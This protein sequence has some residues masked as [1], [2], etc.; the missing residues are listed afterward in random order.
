[1][2]EKKIQGSIT[3]VTV[4]DG[5]PG[6]NGAPGTSTYTYVRYA[7]DDNGTNISEI[8]TETTKYIGIIT[9]TSPT[10]P[11]TGYTWSKYVGENG[12]DGKDGVDGKAGADGVNGKSA[13]QLWLDAGN[14][15][16][17]EDY[18]NSLKGQDG[19]DGK[20]GTDGVGITRIEVKYSVSLSST[21][22]PVDWKDSIEQVE[23]Q[24]GM[25]FWTRIETFYSDGSSTIAHSIA[26]QGEK[27]E[28]GIAESYIIQTNVEEINKFFGDDTTNLFFSPETISFKVLKENEVI[29]PK[30][31]YLCEIALLYDE[32]I[33]SLDLADLITFFEGI[34]NDEN[35]YGAYVYSND[36]KVSIK[37][38]EKVLFITETQEVKLDLRTLINCELHEESSY[39]AKFNLLKQ[40]IK[41]ET[42]VFN[43]KIYQNDESKKLITYKTINCEFGLPEEMAKFRL[44]ATQI[45]AAVDNANLIFSAEGLEIINGGFKI[46]KVNEENE[47]QELLYFSNGDLYVDGHG[48]FSGTVIAEKGS[49]SGEIK[50]G[51]GNIGGFIIEDGALY[52]PDKEYREESI[53]VFDE[54]LTYYEK[55]DEEYILTTDQYLF[56][57]K[58]Y[59]TLTGGNYSLV[60][61][62]QFLSGRIYFELDENSNYTKVPDG[63][64]ANLNK[65][66]YYIGSS[67]A[68]LGGQN[69]IIANDIELGTGAKILKHIELGEGEAYIYNP[70]E[71]NGL[72]L[73]TGGEKI[74]LNAKE[75]TLTLG[76]ITLNGKASSISGDG[77]DIRPGFS[78]FDNVRVSG[79][80]TTSIFTKGSTQAVGG[81]MLFKTAYKIE[82]QELSQISPQEEVEEQTQDITFTLKADILSIFASD[83]DVRYI[84]LVAK[85]GSL[86]EYFEV[87]RNF[88]SGNEGD[89]TVTITLAADAKKVYNTLIVLGK[90]EDIIIGVNSENNRSALLEPRGLTISQLNI[91]DTGL[92]TDL[93]AFLGDLTSL[94]LNGYGLYSNNVYLT[95]SLTTES[96]DGKYA[97][98]NTLNSITATKFGTGE[99]D[100][101]S[102]IVFW[103]GAGDN[104]NEAIQNAS[105]QVTEGGSIYA[106]Q[107]FFEDSVIAR[108]KITGADIYAARLHGVKLNDDGAPTEDVGALTVYD[109]SAG[110]I[111]KSV[112]SEGAETETF[113]IG[114]D[115]LKVSDQYFITINDNKAIFT[116]IGFFDEINPKIINFKNNNNNENKNIAQLY[117]E[118]DSFFIEHTDSNSSIKIKNEISFRFGDTESKFVFSNSHFNAN[119]ATANFS[120][121]IRLGNEESN[122]EYRK[123]DNGKGYDLYVF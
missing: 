73:S 113:S 10:A 13:Y 89:E 31:D 39:L 114:A 53:F 12:Q 104:S 5:A 100:D 38:L 15:G 83:E 112:S 14:S 81:A 49:F 66:Y 9:T 99:N 26:K 42:S 21:E 58:E 117:Q 107:G 6:Q 94:D 56:A 88:F 16:S 109:T 98:V 32:N 87:Q 47:K 50:A 60:T 123:V 90:N 22:P 62:A 85:D 71:Y 75:E 69:K 93:K 96:S 115:G 2:A 33:G 118:D 46:T 116:G 48:T 77:F 121:N 18:L 57:E 119:V 27:G 4:E 122:I 3:L 86:G 110:I 40:I 79:E 120:G 55:V 24:D 111:F 64:K 45:Q 29:T 106:A 65:K 84:V 72:F 30:E 52:S 37:L 61:T 17:E 36:V 102:K 76:D 91:T 35:S 97:G 34:D 8:P 11:N 20:D 92:S 82:N 101:K 44:A 28:D 43:F 105:F 51:S 74:Q 59:Y 7:E 25:F 108:S 80:I 63:E 70:S 41:Q 1:M 103:A 67:V 78:S 68:L 19:A 23:V 54:A 95:G